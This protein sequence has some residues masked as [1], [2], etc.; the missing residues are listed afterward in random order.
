LPTQKQPADLT[1][2]TISQEIEF[3]RQQGRRDA[4][5]AIGLWATHRLH[6]DAK[7]LDSLVVAKSTAKKSK[8]RSK[9]AKRPRKRT[10]TAEKID[11]SWKNDFSREIEQKTEDSDGKNPFSDDSNE[12]SVDIKLEN[13]EKKLQ[14]TTEN[15]RES[16]VSFGFRDGEV[17]DLVDPAAE[18][19][20][21]EATRAELSV[22][23]V[24]VSPGQ[25][26][27]IAD[28]LTELYNI[29]KNRA[30]ELREE[31]LATGIPSKQLNTTLRLAKDLLSTISNIQDSVQSAPE[32]KEA[33]MRDLTGEVGSKMTMELR[34][35][36]NFGNAGP[37][38]VAKM[39]E[40]LPI[41]APIKAPK[42][43]DVLIIDQPEQE[44]QGEAL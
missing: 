25:A 40:G 17:L 10:K 24:S 33:L 8:K 6:V 26:L 5:I 2:R 35:E 31:E 4:Q 12:F 39:L 22:R 14:K 42:T 3:Q 18:A 34:A 37:E 9:S 30:K 36:V 32:M 28:E 11:E 21:L 23:A 27:S 19:K 13:A 7:H 44:D 15:F 1:N 41:Y 38:E 20:A 29:Q 16:E 43:S